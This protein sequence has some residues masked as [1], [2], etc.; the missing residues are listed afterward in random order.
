M[1]NSLVSSVHVWNKYEKIPLQWKS[2]HLVKQKK[3]K[4][5]RIFSIRSQCFNMWIPPI[6]VKDK[7]RKYKRENMSRIKYWSFS[8]KPSRLTY[9]DWIHRE[10]ERRTNII[11]IEGIILDRVG[12]NICQWM[13]FNPEHVV[14]YLVWNFT[15]FVG[16]GW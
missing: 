16:Y 2:V 5:T 10:K 4:K 11:S 15:I 8:F 7:E 13:D 9:F 14:R 12:G 1:K 6:W 3:M